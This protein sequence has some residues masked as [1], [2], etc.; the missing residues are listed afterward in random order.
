VHGGQRLDEFPVVR[1][2]C[3]KAHHVERGEEHL[4]ERSVGAVIEDGLAQLLVEDAL[5][6]ID[7]HGWRALGGH[8]TTLCRISPSVNTVDGMASR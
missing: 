2:Q 7:S 3:G 4:L 6:L 1:T 8:S 5:F